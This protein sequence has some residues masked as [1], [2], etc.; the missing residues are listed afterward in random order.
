MHVLHN[1]YENTEVTP[2]SS[3]RR[4]Y[5][6]K[7]H[8]SILSKWF[9]TGVTC[10]FQTCWEIKRESVSGVLFFRSNCVLVFVEHVNGKGVPVSLPAYFR[11]ETLLLFNF[12]HYE[13]MQLFIYM[14]TSFN[15]FLTCIQ[16]NEHP[17]I[18]D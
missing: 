13:Y 15:L 8:G 4:S 14:Y 3:E 18:L 6:L 16:Y 17:H 12:Y 10:C 7:P 5:A 2:L 1:R 11:S 9:Y